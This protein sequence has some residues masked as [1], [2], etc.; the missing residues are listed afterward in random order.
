VAGPELS[1]IKQSPINYSMLT[2]DVVTGSGSHGKLS[3][4][5]QHL[6]KLLTSP[7]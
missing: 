4:T 6:M 3:V 7:D 1:W 2:R 5:G